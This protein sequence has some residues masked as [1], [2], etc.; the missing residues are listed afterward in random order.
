MQEFFEAGCPFCDPADGFTEAVTQFTLTVS[1]SY[2]YSCTAYLHIF[3]YVPIVPLVFGQI[4]IPAT[5]I[6]LLL[7]V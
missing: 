7:T 4:V 3:T 6:V 1:D 5:E 2:N